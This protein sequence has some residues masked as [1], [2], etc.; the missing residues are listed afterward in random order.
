[1]L[2]L[3]VIGVTLTRVLLPDLPSIGSFV[4][5]LLIVGLY[6]FAVRRLGFAPGFWE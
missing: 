2:V 1:M 3:A 4:V 6:P 5:V